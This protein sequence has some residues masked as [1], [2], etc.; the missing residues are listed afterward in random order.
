MG[1]KP[2]KGKRQR[3]GLQLRVGERRRTRAQAEQASL[4]DQPGLKHRSRLQQES[5]PTAD[6]MTE[7]AGTGTQTRKPRL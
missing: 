3:E 2:T 4:G 5:G 1:E 6:S 7:E